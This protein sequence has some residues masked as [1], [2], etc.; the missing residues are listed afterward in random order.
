MSDRL[1][2]AEMRATDR[3]NLDDGPESVLGQLGD[4]RKEI[5][6]STCV[7][8]TNV[9]QKDCRLLLCDKGSRLPQMTKSILP[10]LLIVLATASRS[11]SGSLTS[12]FAGIQ[13]LPVAFESSSADFARRSELEPERF[14]TLT[15]A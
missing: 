10:S 13:V 5:P 11:C 3:V 8:D 2:I 12:A 1:S 9:H 6:S 14:R 15:S 4:R 7:G